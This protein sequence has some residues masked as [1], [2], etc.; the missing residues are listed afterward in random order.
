[1]ARTAALF[2][3]V[4]RALH[5]AHEAGLV[6]RDIKPAN[7]M[8]T[9]GGEPV[10]MDFGLALEESGRSSLTATGAIMGTPA[11][12]APEVVD[13]KI[14]AVD[15]RTDVYSL[16]VSLHEALAGRPPFEAPTRSELYHRILS[17]EAEDARRLNP[18]VPSDLAVVVATAMAKEPDRRYQTALDLAEDLRRVLSHEPIRARPAGPLVRLHRWSRRNPGLAASLAALVVALAGG[19]GVSL[20]LLATSRGALALAREEGAARDRALRE[21]REAQRETAAA[22]ADRERALER[23]V[24][25][26]LAEREDP[27]RALLLARLAVRRHPSPETFVRLRA[28]VAASPERGRLEGDGAPWVRAGFS[29]DGARVLARGAGGALRRRRPRT[30]T[31]SPIGRRA[32]TRPAA[33]R[34]SRRRRAARSSTHAARRSRSGSTRDGCDAWPSRPTARAC[35]RAPTTGRCASGT[36]RAANCSSSSGTTPRCAGWRSRPAGIAR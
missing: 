34:S 22:L 26:A 13:G 6:H 3:R 7:I 30:G 18:A 24:A 21:S 35:S 23:A 9:P 2:E 33:P 29:P 8:V 12:V 14:G 31:T 27:M 4:A 25:S 20:D 36:A 28:A 1:V 17:S 16:G 15:R 32:R 19:L 5:V 11:Y 10:L